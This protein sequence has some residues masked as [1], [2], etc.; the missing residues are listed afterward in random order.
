MTVMMLLY[1]KGVLQI[2]IFND[3]IIVSFHFVKNGECWKKKN[4][5]NKSAHL[6]SITNKLVNYSI[7]TQVIATN[8]YTAFFLYI[9]HLDGASL[10]L[11]NVFT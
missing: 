6:H 10:Y 4:K 7:R 8:R 11:P 3:F 5:T 1:D 9:F 2:I